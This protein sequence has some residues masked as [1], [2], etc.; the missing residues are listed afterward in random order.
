MI[1]LDTMKKRYAFAALGVP[2]PHW[3]LKSDAPSC[4]LVVSAVTV[5]IWDSVRRRREPPGL[6]RL[7]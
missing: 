6:T 1:A 7:A 3:T 4:G 2:R 5:Q